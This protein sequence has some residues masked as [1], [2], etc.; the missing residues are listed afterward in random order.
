MEETITILR[1]DTKE[2]VKS[3]ADLK[4]NISEL[5]KVVDSAEIGSEEYTAALNELRVNQNALK[6]A[7]Y[8]TNTGFV[9]ADKV[10][11]M[12]AESA[13]GASESYNSLVH[14]MAALKEE[15]RSTTDA[16]RRMELGA[17]I[18]EINTKLKEMD[19]LQ[20]N[21]QRNVGNYAGSLKD[22]LGNLPPFLEPVKGGLDKINGAMGLIS[23]N[24]LMGI[25]TLLSPLIMKIVEGV[26]ENE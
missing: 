22:V 26:K 21:F 20:G 3:V 12:V 25:L 14:R 4:Y 2:A 24:P 10:M 5:K 17:Q 6:D 8:A 1:V 9:E 19:A 18:N 11:Q 23:K 16:A 13:T 15:F 7:L